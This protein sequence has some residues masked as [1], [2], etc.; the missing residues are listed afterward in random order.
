MAHDGLAGEA[1][2]GLGARIVELAEQALDVERKRR[3]ARVDLALPDVARA[4]PVDLDPMAVGVVEVQRLADEVIGEAGE[5]DPVARGVRQPAREVGPL[6]EQQREVIEA[7]VAEGRRGVRLLDEHEQLALAGAERGP[8]GTGLEHAQPDRAAVE[9][10]RALETGD[11]QVHRADRRQRRD[12]AVDRHG[13]RPRLLGVARAH[14]GSPASQAPAERGAK[15]PKTR[16]SV[17][18]SS[19]SS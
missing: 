4:V 13:G 2:E 18:I 11:R 7:R 1:V 9:R 16:A 17:A 5:R 14:R 8:A 6:L 12:L 3:Q 10:E 19:S 15:R